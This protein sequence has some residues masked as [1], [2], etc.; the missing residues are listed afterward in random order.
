MA[1]QVAR[2]GPIAEWGVQFGM[3]VTGTRSPFE[4]FQA[5]AKYRTADISAKV[6]QDVLLLAGSEDHY[7]P[8]TQ[9]TGQIDWLKNARSVTARL[10][11]P[12]ES[13]QSHCQVGNPR[14]GTASHRRV[15]GRHA[16]T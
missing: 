13:A 9:L 2:N 16:L 12:Q 6:H 14:A 10:F 3:H 4:F 7:V 5:I 8:T 1:R 11:T 15:A